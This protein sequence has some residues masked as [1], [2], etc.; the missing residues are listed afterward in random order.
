MEKKNRKYK[1][2]NKEFLQNLNDLKG[3]CLHAQSIEFIHPT[4][5]KIVKFQSNL[6]IYF[7]KMFNF[8]NNSTK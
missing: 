6:P 8:L 3:Q 7:K 5:K 4:K 1:K 2:I